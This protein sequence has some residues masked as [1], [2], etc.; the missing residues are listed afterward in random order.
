M[1]TKWTLSVLILTLVTGVRPTVTM[2]RLVRASGDFSM[3]LY[4]NLVNIIDDEN[5]FLSPFS[6]FTAMAMTYAGARGVTAVEIRKTMNFEMYSRTGN[7][8]HDDFRDLLQQIKS[9][10][11][12][13]CT[14]ALANRLFPDKKFKLLSEFVKVANEDYDATP[15][16]LDFAGAADES[17]RYINKWAANATEQKVKNLL[18]PNDITPQTALVLANA[19]YFKAPWRTPFDKSKST[20]HPFYVSADLT[21][22]IPMMQVTGKFRFRSDSALGCNFVELPYAGSRLSMILVIPRDNDGLP[23]VESRLHARE[24]ASSVS[25]MKEVEI[26]VK[27]PKFNMTQRFDLQQVLANMVIIDLF[28]PQ[29][30]LSG[31]AE[32]SAGLHVSGVIHKAFISVNE[33]GTEAAAA[34]GVVTSWAR[35]LEV[36]ADRPF[37]FVIWDQIGMPLFVGR[38]IQPTGKYE[39][40]DT[41]DNTPS[42]VERFEPVSLV[43]WLVSFAM[44]LFVGHAF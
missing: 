5:I 6:V 1:W 15:E 28:T 11:N 39:T 40:I 23:A 24:L 16:S 27:M 17:R 20:I 36:V 7:A 10:N 37:M 44:L 43:T 42:A 25:A 29:A 9:S 18:T 13:N 32:D 34:T 30:D 8:L 22:N 19:M 3:R 31:L 21:A 14:L 35:P 41:S 26:T 2:T 33:E 38:F 12:D 4:H